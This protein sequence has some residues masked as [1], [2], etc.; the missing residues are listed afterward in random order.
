MAQAA[1]LDRHISRRVAVDA[2]QIVV[3]DGMFSAD[4][5]GSLHTFI[6]KLPYHLNDTDTLETDY[7]KHWKS[8]LLIPLAL[9]TPVLKECATVADAVFPGHGCVLERVHVN[10]M[11]YGDVQFPHTDADE[12]VTVL[13]YANPEWNEHWFGETIFYNA[14]REALV[15]VSPRPGRVVAF[16]GEMLHRAGVP[17]R[18]CFVPRTTVAFKYRRR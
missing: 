18:E 15:A 3:L 17:S 7:V 16:N 12:G 6:G 13:Y 11:L 8:E 4:A 14:A 2:G 9:A 10:L 5:I 1:D